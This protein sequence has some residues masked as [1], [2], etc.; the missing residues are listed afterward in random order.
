MLVLCLLRLADINSKAGVL[1]LLDVLIVVG[2][3]DVWFL[4]LE[5]LRV[6]V[7]D[8]LD[9]AVPD[10][11]ERLILDPEAAH[12]LALALVTLAVHFILQALGSVVGGYYQAGCDSAAVPVVLPAEPQVALCAHGDSPCVCLGHVLVGDRD[13]DGVV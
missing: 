6:N 2:S 5:G 10:L 1:N 11:D 8:A 9:E 3:I 4:L 7:L 13:E 12:I